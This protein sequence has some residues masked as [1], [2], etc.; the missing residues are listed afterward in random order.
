MKT[1]RKARKSRKQKTPEP[2]EVDPVPCELLGMTEWAGVMDDPDGQKKRGRYHGSFFNTVKQFGVKKWVVGGY[3]VVGWKSLMEEGYS[4]QQIVQGC[5]KFLSQPP[6]RRKF[7]R[8]KT[9]PLYGNLNQIPVRF[10][11]REKDGVDCI[12]VLFVTDRRKCRHFWSEGVK[13]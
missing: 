4:E 1:R 2:L 12:E 13:L 9:K 7:Q 11:M 8:K 3:I 5:L 10:R 6:P